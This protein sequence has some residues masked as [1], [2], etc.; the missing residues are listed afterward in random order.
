MFSLP[1]FSINRSQINKRKFSINIPVY[2][3]GSTEEEKK[4]HW[5]W[6]KRRER[7]N[8]HGSKGRRPLWSGPVTKRR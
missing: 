8:I 2:T 4:G 7:E 5:R 3:C 6:S 1:I